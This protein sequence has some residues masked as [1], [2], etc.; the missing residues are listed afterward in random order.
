VVL[1]EFGHFLMAKLFKVKVY[2]FGI[3][4]PPKLFTFYED[5]SGTQYTLN[6]L[7]FG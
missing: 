5:K 3:G 6:L 2:E 4:L 1:H 7:P